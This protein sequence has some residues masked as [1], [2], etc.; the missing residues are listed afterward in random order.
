MDLTSGP[1]AGVSVLELTTTVGGAFAGMHLADLGASVTKVESPDGDRLRR[2]RSVV[3]GTSKRFQWLHRGKRSLGLNLDH[4]AIAGVLRRL[5]P[6]YAVL[7]TDLATETLERAEID[8]NSLSNA[9]PSLVYVQLS[10]YGG[11]GA[12]AGQ[13]L[14]DSVASAYTGALAME[15][16]VQASGA[17]RPLRQPEV[18]EMA[19][20]I[21]CAIGAC[22]AMY[23]ARR[24]GEGQH[25]EASLLRSAMSVTGGSTPI[26]R[27][28]ATDSVLREPMIELVRQVR[29]D[30]GSYED[31]LAARATGPRGNLGVADSPVRLYYG[32]YVARDGAV[33]LGSLTPANRIASRA[34]LGVED[35]GADS[36]DFDAIDPDNQAMVR[37][38]RAHI[39]EV[40]RTRTVA[41]W[42]EAF[43]E[44]G[45]PIAPVSLPEELSDDEQGSRFFVAFGDPL[46]GTQR[47][48]GPIIEMSETPPAAQGP[49]PTL[50]ADSAAVLA[51]AGLTGD[52]V[53]DLFEAGVSI[54]GRAGQ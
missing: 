41:E 40:M 33:V 52:E 31:V 54:D 37:E 22:A 9:H 8:Y 10:S 2:Q 30:G 17:P 25:V 1:L 29:A 26:M 3:P 34:V 53:A 15:E 5:I 50:H 42:V 49:A 18:P 47:Q 24:T 36:T 28:P 19:S 51:E 45:A 16:T 35:E 39:R 4:P 12:L 43:R 21:A 7:L 46:T 44:A 23:H 14:T 38:M 48:L 32:S 13:P 6:G 11:S 20:G 27:E